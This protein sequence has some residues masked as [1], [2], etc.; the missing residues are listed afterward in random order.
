MVERFTIS[1]GAPGEMM[2]KRKGSG[3]AG[4]KKVKRLKKKAPL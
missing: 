3:V 4:F 1:A 2:S